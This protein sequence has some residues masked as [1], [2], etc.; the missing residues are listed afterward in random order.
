MEGAKWNGQ[1]AE[2]TSAM[3]QGI[4][5][6]VEGDG[7]V[8]K[9][10][11]YVPKYTAE[12]HKE[13]VSHYGLSGEDARETLAEVFK[14]PTTWKQYCDEVSVDKCE[15]PDDYAARYP[16]EDEG[17]SYFSGQS[18]Y[19]GYFRATP[20][21]NCTLNPT[22]CT[23][24]IVAPPCGWSS[25]IDSQLYWN[26]IPLESSGDDVPNGSYSYGEMIAIWNAANATRSD[27][28]MVS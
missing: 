14:R 12:R 2:Y 22:T 17:G 25:F 15:T 28:M 8:G 20:Q 5:D 3:G 27:V 9:I 7:Q 1:T 6:P 24:H 21:N 18:N 23:G 10:S 13:L 11:W 26:N 16:T 19:I 4:I